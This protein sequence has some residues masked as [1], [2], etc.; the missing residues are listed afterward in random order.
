MYYLNNQNEPVQVIDDVTDT[1]SC[2]CDC[3]GNLSLNVL[4]EN[5]YVA[6][7]E[8][9]EGPCYYSWFFYICVAVFIVAMLNSKRKK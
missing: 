6:V 2:G 1:H 7:N 9:D 3:S 5:V 8:S 4:E